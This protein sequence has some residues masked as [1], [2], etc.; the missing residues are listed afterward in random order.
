MLNPDPEANPRNERAWFG[1]LTWIQPQEEVV[2]R[3]ARL[4]SFILPY[5]SSCNL[6]STPSA[7]YGGSTLGS[8]SSTRSRLVIL[9][10]RRSKYCLAF[11]PSLA[12]AD[13][14]LSMLKE[15][16]LCSKKQA[17]VSNHFSDEPL[18][19]IMSKFFV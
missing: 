11:L 4:V 7:R 14:I 6:V 15:I 16:R 5:V 10:T 19:S 18:D 13:R 12:I 2:R 8:T 9:R 1:V 17:W 3:R